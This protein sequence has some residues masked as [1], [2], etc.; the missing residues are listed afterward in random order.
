MYHNWVCY[1][2]CII[3]SWILK[4]YIEWSCLI[5]SYMYTCIYILTSLKIVYSVGN[6]LYVTAILGENI[7]TVSNRQG[8]KFSGSFL[9]SGNLTEMPWFQGI[10]CCTKV[11]RKFFSKDNFWNLGDLHPA[12]F[13][14]ILLDHNTYVSRYH[15]NCAQKTTQNKNF[16]VCFVIKNN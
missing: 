3:W 2:Y 11:Y 1:R 5:W 15:F 7:G 14:L 8:F 9:N 10:L 6:R 16:C 12:D 13:R 4:F